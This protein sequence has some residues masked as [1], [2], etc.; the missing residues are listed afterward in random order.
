MTSKITR[1]LERLTL[2]YPERRVDN[3]T[4]Y[5]A[6]SQIPRYQQPS[7]QHKNSEVDNYKAGPK[8]I[9][10]NK[11]INKKTKVEEIKKK[12]INIRGGK[13]HQLK[14]EVQKYKE[15][16]KICTTNEEQIK[17]NILLSKAKNELN[18]I[19]KKKTIN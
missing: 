1:D 8:P 9:N 18:R 6:G 10:I 4:L 17:Y 7:T 2:K 12:P 11:F 13:K 16:L 5:P 14:K 15:L 3:L 19:R